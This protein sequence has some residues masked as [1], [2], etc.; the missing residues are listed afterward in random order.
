[1]EIVSTFYL[2]PS[3]YLSCEDH[4]EKTCNHQ[5]EADTAYIQCNRYFDLIYEN[6]EPSIESGFQS[7]NPRD[8]R[9]QVA[10]NNEEFLAHAFAYDYVTEENDSCLPV[11]LYLDAFIEIPDE[12]EEY[13]EELVE[14]HKLVANLILGDVE[15]MTSNIELA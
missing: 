14:N 13:V 12:L 15:L 4:D 8:F 3:E 11:L 1:M 10:L 9:V 5:S 2:G 6:S 7:R